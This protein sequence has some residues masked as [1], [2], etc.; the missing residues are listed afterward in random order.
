MRKRAREKKKRGM[1]EVGLGE[2]EGMLGIVGRRGTA[3]S[4]Q[5]HPVNLISYGRLSCVE[6]ETGKGGDRTNS[7][8][9]RM[10]IE[11]NERLWRERRPRM[12]RY[13]RKNLFFT[14]TVARCREKKK[15]EGDQGICCRESACEQKPKTRREKCDSRDGTFRMFFKMCR[16]RRPEGTR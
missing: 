5:A 11:K 1:E 10:C 14:M 12:R 13:V 7:V 16:V 6:K 15:R 4:Q 2:C 3:G 8:P 9:S